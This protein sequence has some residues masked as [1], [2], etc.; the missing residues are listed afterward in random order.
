[1][2]D[3]GSMVTIHVDGREH[4][5]REGD[6]LLES[7]L[8]LGYDLP[9][10][11]WHPELG[12]VGA[13]RQCAVKQFRDADD[14]TGM[15]VMACTTP[16][17]DGLRISI[18]DP[19]VREFRAS[20]IEWMMTNHPHDCPICDE[21]GECHLQ[22]MTVMTGHTVRSHRFN[23]RTFRNQHLGPFINHEMNR[24]IQCYRCVRFYRDYA[25][26]DD[27][28]V[29][30]SRN[31]C[32][33]GRVKDGTL[34]SPFSGNLVEVCPTGVFTDKV[35]KE[36][37]VRKWDLETAPSLCLLCGVG[38]NTLPGERLGRL[39]RVRNR[40]HNDVN[41][42]FLCDRGRFGFEFVNSPDRIRRP[43]VR[44]DDPAG[45]T[46][47][48]RAVARVA[49]LIADGGAI[50]IGSPRASLEANYALRTL[51]GA[52]AFF[53]GVSAGEAELM[54]IVADLL[55]HGP[56]R[57]PSLREVEQ[58][59]AVLILGEDPTNTAPR[60]DLAIRQALL[61]VPLERARELEIPS[62][63][64]A[65]NR[66][67]VNDE[68]GPLY[69]AATG[70]TG[71][72]AFATRVGRAA[73]QNVARVGRAIAAA[74]RS[75]GSGDL[76][77]P[78][79]LAALAEGAAAALREAAR[80]LVVSGTSAGSA[81]ILLAAA[82]VAAALQHD[83]PDTA[84]SLVVPDCNSVGAALLA[85]PHLGDAAGRAG[86]RTAMVLE[87]D[88]SRRDRRSS[89]EAV[90]EPVQHVVVVDALA[91]PLTERAD[92][93]LPAATFAECDGTVVN[94]E[95]RAQ[96]FFR[97]F[98]PDG[99]V[100]ASWRWLCRV[101][102][103]ARGADFPSWRQSD[104]IAA[105]LAEEIPVFSPI[106]ELMPAP[107][108]R[109]P[110]PVPRQ[111]HRVTGRTAVTAN[112][113]IHE[114]KPPVDDDAPLAF[115][116]EGSPR[117]PPAGLVTRYWAPGWNSVQALN[118]FQ[119]EIAGPLR[120]GDP[121]VR[122]AE[123]PV[124]AA[125]FDSGEPPAAFE[126]Q[127]DRWLLVPIHHLYGSE[128]LSLHTPGVA[129]QAPEPYVALHPDDG[130]RLGVAVGSDVEIAVGGESIRVGYRP[131]PEV[132]R[133][134]AGLPVGLPGLERLPA[135]DWATLRSAS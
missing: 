3:D 108:G 78:V 9:Y 120:G 74:I 80:P 117:I 6:N 67:I 58:A 54:R 22:D 114:P 37:F 21:G 26:G 31:R 90:L 122:L 34:E 130:A 111:S 61:N 30:G 109:P 98:P 51:V 59:D 28:N 49:A 47:A 100:R 24:C 88:V 85:A 115:S 126:P 38:C 112:L 91:S 57:T 101:G 68:T 79:E 84:L 63:N 36:H 132:P 103:A 62:W 83:R 75:D 18:D 66:M 123:P 127:P 121:G 82:A 13:C 70:R 71:L 29:F 96:R 87:P 86:T 125:G 39:R 11:C 2:S 16:V 56:A 32:Y 64:D 33:F 124:D 65:I 73:P 44:G 45:E 97:V 92:V 131:D 4:E 19:E 95:G 106:A 15:I 134:C 27:L 40:Y 107:P 133:G 12:S 110:R 77:L 48:D 23:K 72:D 55:R 135:G 50:G 17:S 46:S 89:L 52:D 93:V 1:M 129:E 42:Y 20:V 10:F 113:D 94:H 128:P 14:D 5:A 105:A 41:R 60:L 104:E 7:V 69:I 35:S 119:E 116:M 43:V 76:D 118:R 8:G 25:R 81:D 53:I 102:A 99:D